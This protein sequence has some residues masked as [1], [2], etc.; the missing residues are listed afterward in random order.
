[1]VLTAYLNPLGVLLKLV[2]VPSFNY[3]NSPR[4]FRYSVQ[5]R[6]NTKFSM[7]SMAY[8]NP[9]GSLLKLVRVPLSK[10]IFETLAIP[11]RFK[12]QTNKQKQTNK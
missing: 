11:V 7:V 5:F 9:I 2:R 4:G 10:N 8:L 6:K 1:M 3:L 12:K